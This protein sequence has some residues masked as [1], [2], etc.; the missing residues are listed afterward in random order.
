MSSDKFIAM[1]TDKNSFLGK[2]ELIQ[3]KKRKENS[4][5]DLN[6]IKHLPPQMHIALIFSICDTNQNMKLTTQEAVECKL[7]MNV[8]TKYDYDKSNTIEENDI[9]KVYISGEFKRLDTD[10]N[11]VIDIEELNSD[12][13]IGF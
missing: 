3:E 8:F 11:N 10:V 6:D 2:S 4:Q 12:Y 5:I 9:D 13:F 7:N 1:D